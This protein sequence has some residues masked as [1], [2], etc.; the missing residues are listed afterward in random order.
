MTRRPVVAR[1]IVPGIGA[2]VTIPGLLDGG[3]A[4]VLHKAMLIRCE[5]MGIG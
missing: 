2:A 4:D 3:F 1:W 5:C